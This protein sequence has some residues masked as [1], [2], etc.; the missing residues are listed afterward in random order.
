MGTLITMKCKCQAK[1]APVVTW[2]KDT[3]QVNE[4]S[5]IK[6]KCIA[7]DNDFYELVLEVKEPSGADGGPYRCHVKNVHGESNAKLNL[8]IEADPEPEGGAPTFIEKPRIESS[9]DPKLS[10]VWTRETLV[11]KESSRISITIVQDKDSYA[12]KLEL[13]DP[14]P[15]DAGLYKCTVKNAH[16]E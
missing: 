7:L 14:Q 15:S 12:I 1:P 2:F 11:V 6:M 13:K 4:S 16:G 5:K 10:V 8:N 3:T 9:A